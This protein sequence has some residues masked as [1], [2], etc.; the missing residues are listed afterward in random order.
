MRVVKPKALKWEVTLDYPGGLKAII[1]VLRRQHRGSEKS[2]GAMG[3]GLSL[4]QG[5][6]L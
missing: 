3:V 1:R 4:E 6:V 5:R 2:E